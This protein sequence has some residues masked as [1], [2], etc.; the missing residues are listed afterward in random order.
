[1]LTVDLGALRVGVRGFCRLLLAVAV[2]LLSLS[3]GLASS[4]GALPL[5]N[6]VGTIYCVASFVCDVAADDA[7]VAIPIE[8]QRP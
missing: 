8:C 5:G 1:M 2:C 7:L 4:A 6:D 3:H